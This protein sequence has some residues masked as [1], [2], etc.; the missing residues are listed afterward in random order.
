MIIEIEMDFNPEN[1]ESHLR[2]RFRKF[3]WVDMRLI[4]CCDISLAILIIKIM[5]SY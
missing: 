4:I 2:T 1:P 5:I 3:C